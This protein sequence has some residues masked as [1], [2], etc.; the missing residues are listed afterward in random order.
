MLEASSW[1][2]DGQWN[3]TKTETTEKYNGTLQYNLGKAV[4]LESRARSWSSDAKP[5]ANFGNGD[6]WNTV[7]YGDGSYDA[8]IDNK[9]G[10]WSVSDV[11][12]Y[13]HKAY[14]N[15]TSRFTSDGPYALGISLQFDGTQ[16]GVATGKFGFTKS[17]L[18][19]RYNG[20]IWFRSGNTRLEHSYTRTWSSDWNG[21]GSFDGPLA[22]GDDSQIRNYSH[23]DYSESYDTE[24]AKLIEGED[25]LPEVTSWSWSFDGLNSWTRT[26]SEQVNDL[27]F[28][29]NLGRLVQEASFSRSFSSD[30][31]K[32][33]AEDD[34]DAFSHT[35]PTAQGVSAGGDQRLRRRHVRRA[36]PRL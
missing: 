1:S 23:A 18:A 3:W 24:T 6:P 29:N 27:F 20:D 22:Y 16:A 33:A 28:W 5:V 14:N 36:A 31:A 8:P 30:D 4:V 34:A 17:E 7:D 9:T 15:E 2:F 11:T 32:G 25:G 12:T 35:A 19:Q 13:F 10:G 26:V 21:G